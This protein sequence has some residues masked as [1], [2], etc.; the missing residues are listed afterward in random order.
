M[1]ELNKIAFGS[2]LAQLR[3]EKGMTQKELAACL[4]VS[5]KA[6]SKWER[7]LSLAGHRS[8]HRDRACQ[9]G[10]AQHIAEH[11]ARFHVG[12]GNARTL[13]PGTVGFQL[14]G[15]YDAH[16]AVGFARQNKRFAFAIAAHNGT[17]LSQ[18]GLQL[19]RGQ[20]IE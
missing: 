6:V 18:Q 5:D 19:F 3:R 7:G 14:T 15:Q 12:D 8:H 13:R 20:T 9:T 10:T 4:Y 1:Y 2:F 11:A 16:P 17:Q